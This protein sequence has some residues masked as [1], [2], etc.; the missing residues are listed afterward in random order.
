[1]A[2][3][4]FCVSC[5]SLLGPVD[6]DTTSMYCDKCHRPGELPADKTVL[7][8]ANDRTRNREVSAIELSRLAGL[9]TT[10]TVNEPCPDCKFPITNQVY[11]TEYNFTS[12]CPRCRSVYDRSVKN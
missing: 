5:N 4:F 11:D 12:V 3:P 9:P 7:V 2:I 10:N 1:M 8:I 6:M